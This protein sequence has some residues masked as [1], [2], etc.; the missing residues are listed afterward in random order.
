MTAAATDSR[1]RFLDATLRVVRERGYTG[2]TVDDICA[3]AGLT[4][5]SFFHH[6]ES[7]EALGIAAA[8]HWSRTTGAFFASAYY[9]QLADPLDRLL[10]YVDFRRTLL[11]G[12]LAE[13]TCYAGTTVQETHATHPALR[14]A[15]G[16][17]ITDHADELARDIEAAK[18]LYARDAPWT[19]ESL[20]L[21]MQAVIQGAFIVAKAT[22]GPEAADACIA[23]LGR[24]IASLF[25][26][27]SSPKE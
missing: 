7:K 10:G 27:P 18:R 23:H 5:G 22:G 17:C 4:R 11:R 9:R 19:P 21:H 2:A 12:A 3:A 14:S 13:F 8:E 20:G 16:R 15:A 26:R 6:F 25:P 1:T 24:Y